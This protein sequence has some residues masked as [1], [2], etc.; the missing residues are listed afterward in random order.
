MRLACVS[1]SE[2]ARIVNKSRY[3]EFVD[4]ADLHL[5]EFSTHVGRVTAHIDSDAVQKCLL[6]ERHVAYVLVRLRRAP[7]LDR[8]WREIVSVL[9]NLATQI[10]G[11]AELLRPDYYTRQVNEVAAVACPAIYKATS[12]PALEVPDEF[13]RVRFLVQSIV[14]LHMKEGNGLTIST[15]RDE[16]IDGLQSL[17][18]R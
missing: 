12:I 10:H 16:L 4:V 2:A 14:L 15:I 17:T 18:S 13:V 1:G 6:V 3:P 5:A 8:S 11:L 9:G 7:N